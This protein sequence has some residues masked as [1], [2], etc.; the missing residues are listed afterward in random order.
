MGFLS[1]NGRFVTQTVFPKMPCWN[2]YFYSVFWVRA[3]WA[4]L[5]K[6]GIF[7]HPPP[8]KK[9]ILT[10]NWKVLFWYVCVVYFFFRCFSFFCFFW[11]FFWFCFFLFFGGF[12][13]HLA[14]NPP[15]FFF[16]LFCFFFVIFLFF[17]EGLRVR[18]GGPFCASNRQKTL[19]SP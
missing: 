7:G 9:K 6:K 5:S 13:A 3:F 19:F 18:W 14:L 2:S 1:K 15:Y 16:V 10:D 12:K 8:P 11:C 17:F 4:K